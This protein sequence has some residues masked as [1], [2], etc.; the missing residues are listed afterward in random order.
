MRNWF[1]PALAILVISLYG[2]L[3]WQHLVADS[4][5]A[6]PYSGESS[7]RRAPIAS[8]FSFDRGGRKCALPTWRG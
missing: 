6:A 3:G 5:L 8:R 7:E 2:A 4:R 1:P